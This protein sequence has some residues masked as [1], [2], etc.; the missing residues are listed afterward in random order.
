[1][2]AMTN[3]VEYGTCQTTTGTTSTVPRQRN[4][5]GRQQGRPV[6]R[7]NLDKAARLLAKYNGSDDK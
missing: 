1:M 4:D 3:N 5:P 6:A 2:D 7:D